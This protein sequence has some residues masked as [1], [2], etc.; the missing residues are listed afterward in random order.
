[1]A[2]AAAAAEADDVDDAVDEDDTGVDIVIG[3]ALTKTAAA[4]AL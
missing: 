3:G 1:L 4:A 2:S